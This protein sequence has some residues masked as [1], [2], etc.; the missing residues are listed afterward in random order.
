MVPRARSGGGVRIPE[1]DAE[2][3]GHAD[4]LAGGLCDLGLGDRLALDEVVDGAAGALEVP[5][6][7]LV[8]ALGEQQVGHRVD[9]RLELLEQ[10]EKLLALVAGE[11]GP[12]VG[13]RA[14]L[15]EVGGGAAAVL[16]LDAA[17]ETRRVPVLPVRQQPV[18]V[19]HVA[20]RA[21][22]PDP[23]SVAPVRVGILAG[24]LLVVELS[25]DRGVG[26]PER[27]LVL[28][29][30]DR[31]VVGVVVGLRALAEPAL[32]PVAEQRAER[33]PLANALEHPF[34]GP[35]PPRREVD[36]EQLP[37]FGVVVVVLPAAAE[38][39]GGA[40][41]IGGGTVDV[42]GVLAAGGGVRPGHLVVEVVGVEV[43][44]EGVGADVGRRL[45]RARCLPSV[46]A[47]GRGVVTAGGERSEYTPAAGGSVGLGVL[48][49]PVLR[50]ALEHRLAGPPQRRVLDVVGGG[51]LLAGGRSVHRTPAVAGV[52]HLRGVGRLGPL[53]ALEVVAD[54]LELGAV[55]EVDLL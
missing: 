32:E 18:A 38:D 53:A 33:L 36:V 40:R 17:E 51:V 49:V 52:V 54:V 19:E 10:A 5:L 23:R 27:E 42:L 35:D 3:V 1:H 2:P 21:L 44:D 15:V 8:D 7:E 34:S 55:V 47:A 48:Q 12:E 6:S 13:E 43:P 4:V 46:D 20:F 25:L 45:P 39:R 31:V 16:V 9:D 37:E 22:A 14:R 29:Q 41:V 30:I 28:H 26:F 50:L 24:V 11:C